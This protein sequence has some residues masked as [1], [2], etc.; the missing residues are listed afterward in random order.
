MP[1]QVKP[2]S[3]GRSHIRPTH[4]I[5]ILT[6]LLA[7]GSGVVAYFVSSARAEADKP[8]LAL[9]SLVRDLR[10]FHGLHG[11]FPADLSVV[12]EAIW[13]PRGVFNTLAEANRSYSAANYY[14]LYTP[15][16]PHLA[17]IWAVPLGKYRNYY[18]TYYISVRSEDSQP[19]VWKGPALDLEQI[20]QIRGLMRDADLINLGLVLQPGE[21]GSPQ[22]NAAGGQSAPS[23]QSAPGGGGGQRAPGPTPSPAKNRPN[24]FPFRFSTN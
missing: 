1:S 14:Y 11:G 9:N 22:T 18:S 6:F 13:K 20:K 2:S 10:M 17:N 5:T 16:G 7:S 8:A 21:Q 12:S 19:V 15:A 24:D 23:P 3:S 4:I